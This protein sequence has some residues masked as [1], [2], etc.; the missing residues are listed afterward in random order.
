MVA[1]RGMYI[2]IAAYIHSNWKGTHITDMNELSE[3]PTVVLK[4]IKGG[5]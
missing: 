2:R 1:S 4:V 3:M 5:K